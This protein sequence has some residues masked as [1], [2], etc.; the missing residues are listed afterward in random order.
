MNVD[1]SRCRI[2]TPDDII[3]PARFIYVESD[4]GSKAAVWVEERRPVKQA[5]RVLLSSGTF[6]RSP[7]A[8]IPSTF[9]TDTGDV[10]Q[11]TQLAGGCGCNARN[12]PLAG[13]TAAQLLDPDF[14]SV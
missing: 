10:W 1:I 5:H 13:I 3:S 12:S 14:S 6:T 7:T 9:T 8:R 11:I 2:Q 4:E